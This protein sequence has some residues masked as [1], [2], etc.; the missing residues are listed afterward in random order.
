MLNSAPISI[1]QLRIDDEIRR[2]VA[3]A[4][5][6]DCVVSSGREACR[7]AAA[8]GTCGQ[9]VE[10]ISEQIIKAAIYAGVAVEMCSPRTGK[11]S[12]AIQAH[13]TLRM[14]RSASATIATRSVMIA[15]TGAP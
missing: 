15:I 2:I 1:I 9:A 5:A 8:F 11:P 14:N 12:T 10:D 3:E 7:L 13:D 6:S 4:V